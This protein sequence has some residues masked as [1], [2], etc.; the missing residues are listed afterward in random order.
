MCVS[1]CVGGLMDAA[2]AG[3]MLCHWSETF[4]VC[5]CVHRSRLQMSRLEP[6][7]QVRATCEPEL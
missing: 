2:C 7:S 1:V 6:R 3:V 5:L 4:T